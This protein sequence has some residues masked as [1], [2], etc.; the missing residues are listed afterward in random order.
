LATSHLK[1][2]YLTIENRLTEASLY[3]DS[4]LQF[5]SLWD[6]QADQVYNALG[7]DLANWLQILTE[8][9][10][11]R[12]TFDTSEVF[13]LFGVIAIT[14]DQVQSRVNAKYDSWQ[15]DI[16]QRFAGVLSISMRELCEELRTARINLERQSLDTS[17]TTQAVAFITIVQKSE[18]KIKVWAPLVDIFKRSQATLSRERYHFPDDWLSVEQISGEWAAF[19]EILANKSK[20]VEEQTGTI[21]FFTINSF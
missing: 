6:L 7:E 21:L 14:F 13:R 11:S 4:W 5:Q 8:I 12:A 9:R 1:S 15:R 3:V 19:R 18:Q 2:A 10:K 20:Q 17:N 16:V